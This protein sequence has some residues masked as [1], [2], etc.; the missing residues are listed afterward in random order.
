MAGLDDLLEMEGEADADEARAAGLPEDDF[1]EEVVGDYGVVQVPAL[2]KL[3]GFQRGKMGRPKVYQDEF[4]DLARRAAFLGATNEDL[5]VFFGVS[6]STIAGWRRKYPEFK[7]A[8][9]E[10]G[11]VA[12]QKVAISL[13]K[14]A[15]G[16]TKKV[17]KAFVPARGQTPV[18]A[19]YDEEV[20]PDVQ[21][22]IHW[23]KSRRKDLW[24]EDP[25]NG[26]G[27][28]F[29]GPVQINFGAS[30]PEKRF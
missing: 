6:A 9:L 10:G 19:E 17:R 1:E 14:R 26:G 12:D 5:G 22:Q 2:A 4:P 24:G 15:I 20:I 21:A 25:I 29:N 7:M 23:L 18:I 3:G 28:T 27:A 11:A 8:V 16:Y 13:Y 30:S